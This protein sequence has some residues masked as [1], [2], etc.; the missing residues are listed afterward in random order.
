[1]D[2]LDFNSSGISSNPADSEASGEIGQLEA[3]ERKL[4]SKGKYLEAERVHHQ[5]LELKRQ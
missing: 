4:V 2:F 5:I 1:M 3:K